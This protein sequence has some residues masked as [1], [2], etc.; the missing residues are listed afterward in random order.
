MLLSIEEEA[1]P[2]ILGTK[3]CTL[4]SLCGQAFDTPTLVNLASHS[5]CLAYQF[6]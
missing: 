4:A 2:L 5:L 1:L 3:D 6:P